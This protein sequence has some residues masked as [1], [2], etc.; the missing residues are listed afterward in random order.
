[1]SPNRTLMSSGSS[2]REVLR[3]RAQDCCAFF[4]RE[5]VPFLV[6]GVFHGFEFDDMKGFEAVPD[7]L[8]QEEG[9]CPLDD[10]QQNSQN[11]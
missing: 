2:S 4:I 10:G 7:A 9:R 5:Q 1:M 8:L 6:P 11:G 3:S